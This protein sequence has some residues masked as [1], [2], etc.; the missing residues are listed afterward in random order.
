MDPFTQTQFSLTDWYNS[1]KWFT[2]ILINIFFDIFSHK[3]YSKFGCS[4]SD[5]TKE[6]ND[7]RTNLTTTYFEF[8]L[9]CF[10]CFYLL[11]ECTLHSP[12]GVG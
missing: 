8:R 1:K 6:L 4:V 7:F 11:S 5:L 3:F 10:I 12:N 9:L 2:T